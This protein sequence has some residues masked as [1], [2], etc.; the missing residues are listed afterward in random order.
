L[1]WRKNLSVKIGENGPEGKCAICGKYVI[2]DGI[3]F[4]EKS[5][6]CAE[7]KEFQEKATF[8]ETKGKR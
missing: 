5:V 8:I 1:I 2:K 6:L 7:C 3:L 4:R